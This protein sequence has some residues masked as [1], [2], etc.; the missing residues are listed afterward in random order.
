MINDRWLGQTL[1]G[2]YRIEELLGQ[3][4]M[5]SVYRAVDP[6]LRRVV[7]VK[8]IHPHL[9]NNEEFVRRF[10]E[11]ASSVAQLRH[12]NIIQVYDF[13]HDQG[14][15]YMVMEFVLGETLQQRMKRLSANQRRLPYSEIIRYIIDVCEA[16]DYAHKRQMIHRD[17]KPANIML[18]VNGHAILMDFGIAKIIGGHKH[19]ATGAVIGTA[20]YMSPE[21]VRGD[22]FDHRTDIYSIGIT[23]FEMVH[24]RPPFDADS[25]M[26]L[27][28]KHLNEPVPDLRQLQPDAPEDLIRVIEK[29]LA[30]D[31]AERYQSAAEMSAALRK[32]N[33]SLQGQALAGNASAGMVQVYASTT[34]QSAAIESAVRPLIAAGN[35]PSASAS[36]E[37]SAVQSGVLPGAPSA[38]ALAEPSRRRNLLMVGGC[39]LIL[40][41][42]ICFVGGAAYLFNQF[43]P[44]LNTQA[45]EM[46]SIATQT[47]VA[48]TRSALFTAA[49]VGMVSPIPT[50]TPAVAVQQASPTSAPTRTPTLDA[51]KPTPLPPGFPFVQIISVKQEGD[52]YQVEYETVGFIESSTGRHIHFFFNNIN[53]NDAGFPGPGPWFMHTGP[54]P[55]IAAT[56]ADRP[57]EATQICALVAEVNHEVIPDSGNCLDLPPI[58]VSDALTPSPGATQP[59]PKPTK[60]RREPG[61]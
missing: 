21:Q 53:P 30:K 28:M 56:L 33:A 6:N 8:M 49:V 61:Y 18:D 9:S 39:A 54:R 59:T 60:E 57:P 27:M 58:V 1:G 23:L 25:T 20:M 29:A 38:G 11:E 22:R 48:Q 42:L 44:G 35:G 12:P 34:P 46:A 14:L 40:A 43:F 16:V 7:A 15:Y 37:T 13:N 26:T 2:R 50:L 52:F 10:E 55:F 4:G 19:T 24:G 17:I 5:S 31:P 32:V 36:A 47:A 51:N 41:A 3:G 45:T